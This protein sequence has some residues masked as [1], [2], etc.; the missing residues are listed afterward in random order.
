MSWLWIYLVTLVV[1][2][3][4]DAVWL[5]LIAMPF[6]RA[7]IGPLLL[8]Q[9]NLAVAFGFYALY[10]VGIVV[11]ALR[12]ALAGGGWQAALGYGALFGLIAYAT[13]DLTNLAV[14]RGWTV[15]VALVDMAW[16]AILTGG[17]AAIAFLLAT[18]VL[19]LA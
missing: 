14:L 4:I 8:D 12:P 5:G 11:F 10:C 2:L 3:A 16:G 15:T 6:Y 7:Q 19:R 18:R 17:T 1:F 13:Y 9:P